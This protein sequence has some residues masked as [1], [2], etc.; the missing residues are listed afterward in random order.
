MCL[1]CMGKK[2]GTWQG[3]LHQRGLTRDEPTHSRAKWRGMN[4]Q[5]R[6]KEGKRE[7]K[8]ETRQGKINITCYMCVSIISRRHLQSL[9]VVYRKK[10]CRRRRKASLSL[11]H[12]VS[13]IPLTFGSRNTTPGVSSY[14]WLPRPT[15]SNAPARKH[16]SSDS[17]KQISSFKL[18]WP[19]TIRTPRTKRTFFYIYFF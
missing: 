2:S 18:N 5:E 11:S 7:R 4:S 12:G 1:G 8:V 16:T 3:W 19:E 9:L 10:Q 15:G 6:E 13:L 14:A 17:H